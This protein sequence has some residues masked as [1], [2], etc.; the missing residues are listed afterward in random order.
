M[1]SVSDRLRFPSLAAFRD[2]LR[3]YTGL[4]PSEIRGSGAMNTLWLAL[5]R[6]TAGHDGASMDR[7]TD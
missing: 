4:S 7:D 6:E 2:Q 3:R 5:E 1:E